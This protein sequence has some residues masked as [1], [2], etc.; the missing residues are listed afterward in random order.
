MFNRPAVLFGF[1]LTL[2]PTILI[3]GCRASIDSTSS[4]AAGYVSENV[5][6]VPSVSP[7]AS[8]SFLVAPAGFSAGPSPYVVSTT[9][10]MNF[11]ATKTTGDRPQSKLWIYDNKYWCIM[12]ISTGTWVHRLDGDTWSPVLK[13]SA[14]TTTQADVLPSGNLVH[15]LLYVNNISYLANIEYVPGLATGYRMWTTQPAITTL[16]LDRG[17]SVA[18]I[19][20]DSTGRMWIVSDVNSIIVARNSVAPYVKWSSPFLIASG[21]STLDISSVIALPDKSIGVFWSNQNAKRF[22]F[23]VHRDSAGPTV[24]QAAE[25]PANLAAQTIGNGMADAQISVTVTPDNTVFAAVKTKYNTPTQPQIGL[26]VRRPSGI[27]DQTLYPIDNRGIKP[28]VTYSSVQG[29]VR[30]LY[31]NQSPTGDIVMKEAKISDLKFSSAR[32]LFSAGWNDVTSMKS[33]F[34]QS[35]VVMATQGMK[36][37]SILINTKPDAAEDLFVPFDGAESAEMTSIRLQQAIDQASKLQVGIRL[38]RQGVFLTDRELKVSAPGPLFIDGQGAFIKKVANLDPVIRVESV[39]DGFVLK[40]LR[41]LASD[42]VWSQNGGAC[43]VEWAREV[44][45]NG[46]VINGGRW[47]TL[48]NI[49]VQHASEAAILAEPTK[50]ELIGLKLENLFIKYNGE[51]IRLNGTTNNKIRFVTLA[52][53]T[54][55]FTR[56]KGFVMRYVED[57]TWRGGAAESSMGNNIDATDTNRIELLIYT[58]NYGGWQ[59]RSF[60]PLAWCPRSP[61]VT[62]IKVER[63]FNF[64]YR[65][66]IHPETERGTGPVLQSLSAGQCFQITGGGKSLLTGFCG[67]TGPIPPD[68]MPRFEWLSADEYQPGSAVVVEPVD[69]FDVVQSKFREAAAKR[70]GVVLVPQTVYSWPMLD[71]KGNVDIPA[72]I[73]GRGATINLISA[74]PTVPVDAAIKVNNATNWRGRDG[75]YI[76]DLNVISAGGSNYGIKLL[77]GMGVAVR[78]VFVSGVKQA[79]IRIEGQPGAGFYYST[80]SDIV[81]SDSGRGLDIVSNINEKYANANFIQNLKTMTT[82]TALSFQGTSSTMVENVI[83]DWSKLPVGSP[84][85]LL[86]TFFSSDIDIQQAQTP[87]LTPTAALIKTGALVS[88]LTVVYSAP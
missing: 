41:I 36:V 9:P 39:Q 20:K 58:E 79:G 34:A 22:G 60:T 1:V 4:G 70:Q 18:T 28:I 84:K 72:F 68:K 80:F 30:V 45:K 86:D 78:R 32:T 46:I 26:L 49:T 38:Q 24:W 76:Q 2:I 37:G 57:L 14:L 73:D 33:N 10:L 48:R 15:A 71:L 81:V 35:T 53:V 16:T 47:I 43:T 5:T 40:N 64:L 51:G 19:T 74:D 29:L 3:I 56:I 13:L 23:R 83:A 88:G 55:G 27:W 8:S 87:G 11:V 67:A 59:I 61:T 21:V 69:T 12:P 25:I 50:Q 66:R 54:I 85:Y 42:G 44:A 62:A 31:T 63:T 75:F 17:I 65:G 82:G 7:T 6:P 52:G 77:G